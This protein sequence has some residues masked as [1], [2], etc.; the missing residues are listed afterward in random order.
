MILS[1]ELVKVCFYAYALRMKVLKFNIC[2]YCLSETLW[3]NSWDIWFILLVRRSE[4]LL[5][6]SSVAAVSL[7]FFFLCS[8]ITL[9]SYA[10]NHILHQK[11]FGCSSFG[12]ENKSASCLCCTVHCTVQCNRSLMVFIILRRGTTIVFNWQ[13]DLHLQLKTPKCHRHR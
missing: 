9:S 2:K 5:D 11:C 6:G 7:V 12:Q 4:L 3:E 1:I 13:F 8:I 10:Q